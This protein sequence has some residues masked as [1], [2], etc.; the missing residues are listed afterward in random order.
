ME[1]SVVNPVEPACKSGYSL[2]TEAMY[3]LV[4]R[5]ITFF[6][7]AISPLVLVRLLSVEQ[8]GLYRLVVF[9][10]GVAVLL[11]GCGICNSLYYLFPRVKGR[12]SDLL[13]QTLTILGVISVS[14]VFIFLVISRFFDVVPKAMMGT[15]ILPM[16]TY[17]AVESIA[18]VLDHIFVLERKSRLMPVLNAVNM[19]AYLTLVIGAILV[20]H[21]VI[22][23]AYALVVFAVARLLFLLSYLAK[24]Y[25]IRPGIFD[26]NI[27]DKQLKFCLP[28]VGSTI[29]GAIGRHFSK[30]VV[31]GLMTTSDF[32]VFAVG[33]LGVVNI[34]QMVYTSISDVSVPRFG[35]LAV[36][37]NLEQAKALWDKMVLVNV[38]ITTPVVLFCFTFADQIIT[39]LFTQ[40]Y[41]ASAN[42]FRINLFILLIQMTSYGCIPKAMGKTKAIL[43]GNS[44]RAGFLIPASLLLIT[45]FGL[46]GGAVSFVVC[47]WLNALIQLHT[48]KKV[49]NVSIGQF[50]PWKKLAIIF[51]VSIMPAA[52]ISRITVLEL[53]SINVLLFATPVYFTVI[54][55][56]LKT[57]GYLNLEEIL[58]VL[59]EPIRRILQKPKVHRIS[60]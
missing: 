23:V 56:I 59:P 50:L 39:V 24:R 35:E 10:F 12:H 11:I 1:K 18:L 2:R 47:F 58:D 46:L 17:V 19:I 13:S 6:I 15:F 37:N 26:K 49:I 54:L 28:L 14:F 44:I 40:R 42:I 20:F 30:A 29:V 7:S 53:S 34:V 41:L 5:L 51:I 55:A 52:L 43:L 25:A 4:G 48:A 45:K 57:I 32:A 33:G 60:R 21:N 38:T 31:A 8:Y 22:A 9:V 16:A 36:Q 3:V 27:L